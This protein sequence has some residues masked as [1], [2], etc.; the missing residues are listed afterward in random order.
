MTLITFLLLN[1]AALALVHF[2]LLPTAERRW[3]QDRSLSAIGRAATLALL[4]FFRGVLLVTTLTTVALL[5]TLLGLRLVGRATTAA[6]FGAAVNTLQWLRSVLLG[7]GPAWG[8]LVMTLLI[9][10]LAVYARYSGRRRME[11]AFQ[12]AYARKLEELKRDYELGKLKE[13]PPTSEMLEVQ[14][15]LS[16]LHGELQRLIYGGAT[17]PGD[18]TRQQELARQIHLLQQ[19]YVTLDMQRRLDAEL[20]PEE[21]ELPAPRTRWEQVQV[22][23][24]SRGLLNSLS[25]GSRALFLAG[26]FLLVPSLLGL[27]S[28]QT[29][30]AVERRLVELRDLHVRLASE[31]VQKDKEALGQP[32]DELSA[33]ELQALQEVARAFEDAASPFV[34]PVG[35]SGPLYTMRATLVREQVLTQAA[36]QAQTVRE[37]H[38]STANWEPHPT[39]SQVETLSPLE[40]AVVRAPEDALKTRGPV[41]ERGRRVL[42]ELTDIA[43]RSSTLRQRLVAGLRNFQTPAARADI[44]RALFNQIV[45]TML[46]EAPGEAGN[47]LGGFDV[48]QSNRGSIKSVYET[49]PLQF[50]SDVVHG[51]PVAE[52]LERVTAERAG[53]LVS[54]LEQSEYQMAL[55]TVADDLPLASINQK[56]ADYPPTVDIAPE[57]HVN[58]TQ[59]ATE[60]DQLR[61]RAITSGRL[62][63]PERLA[64]AVANFPDWFPGQ[65]GADAQTARGRL[66]S[67]WSGSNPDDLRPLSGGVVGPSGGGP[68]LE[69]AVWEE[70]AV[71]H[72][73]RAAAGRDCRPA[74]GRVG[75]RLTLRPTR[76]GSA[77][78]AREVSQ[79]Y[80]ASRASAAF[81]SANCLRTQARPSWISLIC[82]GKRKA[83]TCASCLLGAM[84][85]NCAR[86][87]TV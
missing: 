35:A 55:R 28:H 82:V 37:Q 17:A 3:R 32:G 6:E 29:T 27:Y 20:D 65:L 19:L 34:P 83:R 60:I 10:A 74:A 77:S 80:V 33:D 5:L 50:I 87:R 64:D 16:E 45:S 25:A 73:R 71:R 66:L 40:R 72:S 78:C 43:R 30:A 8:A 23:F 42:A 11:Q 63:N 44:S 61:T 46:G 14:Q 70:A 62:S 15:R 24:M 26:L 53:P 1:L 31:E 52:A 38:A 81:S 76:R 9:I 2:A 47:L 59:A 67:R 36:R 4:G 75:A 41:T 22:F 69:A 51:R 68:G 48:L 21:A 39:G 49:Q 56:L 18:E 79:G 86:A 13:L 85:G 54:P 57:A 12:R 7:F 58:L 84:G